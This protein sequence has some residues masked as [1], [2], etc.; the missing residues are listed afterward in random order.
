M[1]EEV[2]SAWNFVLQVATQEYVVFCLSVK[3]LLCWHYM[4][5]VK[6]I[7]SLI[8]DLLLQKSQGLPQGH[9]GWLK[10]ISLDSVRM[11]A[12]VKLGVC[13]LSFTYR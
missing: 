12:V 8:D 6:A 9:S 10:Y 4:M 1:L 5:Q 2:E 7:G 3:D 11:K 13:T